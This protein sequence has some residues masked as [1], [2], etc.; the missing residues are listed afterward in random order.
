[1]AVAAPPTA[2][3][4]SL[5]LRLLRGV[6][7]GALLFS[8]AAGALAYWLGH[9]HAIRNSGAVLDGLVTSIE[10]TAAVGAFAGDSVLSREIAA[11]LASNDLVAAAEVRAVD[12]TVLGS[13]VRVAQVAGEPRL[14]IERQLASPF[15]AS[16]VVG[17]LIVKANQRR[18]E[19][20]ALREALTLSALMIT[21]VLLVALLLYAVVER[22]VSQPIAALAR[23]LNAIVPGTRE[24]LAAPRGHA[25]DEI[26]GLVAGANALLRA[27]EDA[28]GR[29]RTARAEIEQTVQQRTAELRI[30]KEAAEAASQA[31]SEFLATMSHE[32][33]TPMN[34]VL[35]MTELLLDSTLPP[36]QRMWAEGVQ[37]SGRYL[38]GVINDILDFSKIES[39]QME[40]DVVEF[41][42]GDVVEDAVAMFAQPA[43]SKG[44]ELATRFDPVGAPLQVVGDPFRLRQVI[45]NL[46]GNAVK[47]TE[48]GEV[49][50]SVTSAR[51]AVNGVRVVIDVRDTG[52]GIAPEHHGKIFEHFAQADG[53]T[54]RRFGGTG[55]GLAICRRLL[56]LMGGMISVESQLGQG[57]TFRIQLTLPLA[58][59][60]STPSALDG[61]S[62]VRVLVVDDNETNRDI[63]RHQLGGWGMQVECAV[64]GAEALDRLSRAASEGRSFQLA[65]L[66]MHMPQMD[67]LQLAQRIQ[68]HPE[69]AATRLMMLSSTYGVADAQTRSRVGIRRCVTKP[70][71][72]ADLLRVVRSV[73]EDGPQEPASPAPA[74]VPVIVRLAGKVLLVE[75]NPINQSVGKAM[76]E[77]IGLAVDVAADG[78]EG[79]DRMVAGRYDLVLMDCQMP[80]MDGYEATALIR[81][82][83]DP[84]TART[85]IIALTANA[86][87]GYEQKC[88]AAGMD[89]FLGKPYTLAQ[90]HSL[91]M[92]WLPPASV[93]ATAAVAAGGERAITPLSVRLNE[94]ALHVL[95]ELDPEGGTGLMRSLLATYIEDSTRQMARIDA[96]LASADSTEVARSAHTLKSSS[97]NVGADSLSVFF[98]ELEQMARQAR[99]SEARKLQERLRHLHAQ[100]LVQ[101]QGL[102]AEI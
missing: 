80:V 77:K 90:L 70:I 47:F 15:D 102:L 59:H 56:D 20:D 41:D 27:S 30:A 94:Q 5:R 25:D 58:S 54:T 34:G 19:A 24:R 23:Q 8:A 67:G 1:M 38:L 37:T 88:R 6:V 62:G 98:Q 11:G 87:E 49:V 92:R 43:E 69:H 68:A 2:A 16:E 95:R 61:L 21:Q 13:E 45:A 66:D 40:L 84:D 83:E 35:G 46:L 42:L 65:V 72:R 100:A 22:L 26:G 81:A 31:K 60:T 63:L 9:Q 82:S 18:I 74:S 85:P 93:D 33:R 97:A 32:I 101:M 51:D 3:Q 89:A 91:L 52:I 86:I 50:V 79:V 71:R 36:Q 28:L 99:L 78:R 10:K 48:Q 64:S 14:A 12:G 39:G 73:L 17:T 76:L 57:A 55:L 75:D 96:A 7:I 44:L 4:R 29:E 53:S